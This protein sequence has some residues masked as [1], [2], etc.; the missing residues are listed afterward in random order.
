[1]RDLSIYFKP[2][3]E[4]SSYK[5]GSLGS[6]IIDIEE[7]DQAS[8]AIVSVPEFRNSSTSGIDSQQEVFTRFISLYKGE[9]DVKILALGEILPGNTLDDTY[10]AIKEVVTELVKNNIVPVVIGGSQDLT[11]AIYQAYEKLEQT[12]NIVDFSPKSDL[13]NPDEELSSQGWLSKIIM[14][15]P[16]YLFNYSLIGYQ[17]YLTNPEELSLLNKMYFDTERLG[18][19]YRNERR[20]EPMVRN[21]D[22]LSFDLDSIRSSDFPSNAYDLPHGFYGEDV[23]RILRYAGMSDK[24]SVLGLFH[25]SSNELTSVESNLIAQLIWHFIDGVANRKKDYP[26]GTKE[27]YLKYIVS[28]D[29]FKDELIFYK[30][31]NSGRWWMQVPYPKT[32]KLK[33]ERHLM[34]PCN[35]EDYQSALQNEMPD[36][37]WKTHQKLI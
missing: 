9:W 35:Y 30:S 13:G 34:V 19:F 32:D 28:L 8:V 33:F 22:I 15:K 11:Y 36:L 31:P 23:C 6:L 14:H 17:N 2:F 29:D 18:T 7:A 12:V 25:E 3:E 37:W 20:M 24:L 1:M 21:A 27:D 4:P 26:I 10:A 5:N 16:S